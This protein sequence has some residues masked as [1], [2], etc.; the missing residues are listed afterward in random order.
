MMRVNGIEYGKT[1]Q[2]GTDRSEKRRTG[3][4]IEIGYT[5]T[6]SLEQN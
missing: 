6:Y 4:C 3:S 5:G 2:T 1:E